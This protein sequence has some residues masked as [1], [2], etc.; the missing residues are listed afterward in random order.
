[1][2]KFFCMKAKQILISILFL[3][4]PCLLSA[5]TFK[6]HQTNT[7]VSYVIKLDRMVQTP[8]GVKLYGNIK[9]KKNF[10]YNFSLDECA[11]ILPNGEIIPGRVQKWNDKKDPSIVNQPISDSYSEHFIIVFPDLNIVDI[12][13]LDLR[14]GTVLDRDKTPIILKDIRLKKK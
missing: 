14:L 7:I 11:I 4:L 6:L 5:Q 10:S 13:E 8:F 12:S 2:F 9:Q 1:M 3:C